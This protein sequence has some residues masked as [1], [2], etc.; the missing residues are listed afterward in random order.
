MTSQEVDQIFY[1]FVAGKKTARDYADAIDQ[2]NYERYCQPECTCDPTRD[3]PCA[4]CQ[5]EFD[6]NRTDDDELPY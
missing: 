6:R 2:Y 1:D 5:A 3:M 4:A